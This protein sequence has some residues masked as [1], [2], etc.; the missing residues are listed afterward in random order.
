[1]L[2]LSKNLSLT[3]RRPILRVGL[4]AAR[5][6]GGAIGGPLFDEKIPF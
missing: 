5:F 6:W 4:L 3:L 2:T 1:M